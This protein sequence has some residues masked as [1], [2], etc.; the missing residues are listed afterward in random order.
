MLQSPP[1]QAEPEIG[2]KTRATTT[3]EKIFFISQLTLEPAKGRLRR[4]AASRAGAIDSSDL[5][6]LHHPPHGAYGRV[7]VIELRSFRR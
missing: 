6:A 3:E 7:F 5:Q 4:A 1:P 2:S